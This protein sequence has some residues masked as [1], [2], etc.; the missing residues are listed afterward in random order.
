MIDPKNLAASEIWAITAYFNPIGFR[1]RLANYRLFRQHLQIPLLAV[2]L[3]FGEDFELDAGDA[4]ILLQ[5]RGRDVMWQKERLL[6]LALEALPARCTK[7]AWLDCDLIFS[8]PD[9]AGR[10]SAALDRHALVQPFSLVHRMPQHWR[11]GDPDAGADVMRSVGYALESGM[12]MDECIYGDGE[13][14]KCARGMAW[15]A[16]RE[17]LAGYGLFDLGI[18]GGGDAIFFR[19]A[20]GYFAEAGRRLHLSG[21]GAERF[22]AWAQPFH[23]AVQGDVS[24]V[25]GD[26]THLWHGAL[27]DR[28]Y[29][30]R[31]EEF[32]AFDFDPSEDI[33][34]DD[35]GAWRWDSP[36][37]E[38]HDF[39]RRYFDGRRED[40]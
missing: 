39:V 4:D 1:R 32:A 40:G 11:P 28:R 9:W 10:T 13:D 31:F 3:A 17:L 36:K 37:S 2:E 25:P 27:S 5:L 8:D 18:L 22:R 34:L 19:S 24:H 26:L 16:R 23:E 30:K 14:V 38:M 21:N 7:V 15:A 20:F 12:S 29:G 35:S 6:N 33:A